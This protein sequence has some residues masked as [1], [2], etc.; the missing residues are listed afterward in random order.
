[1]INTNSKIIKAILLS[2]FISFIIFLIGIILSYWAT[3]LLPGDPITAYLGTHFTQSQYLALY[4]KLG[5]NN[6]LIIQ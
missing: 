5:F 2:V 4:K 3:Y 1:M 6:L